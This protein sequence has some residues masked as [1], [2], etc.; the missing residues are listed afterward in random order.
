[1]STAER[2]ARE[3]EA[4]K[5]LILK[6]AK[7]LFLERGIEQTT[8][9][10]IADEIDY[11]VGT[12]YVYF[13]DKNAILHDLHSIGFQELGGYFTELFAIKDPMER[14]RKM[15]FTYL[16]F[17][18]ENSEMYDLM[19]IVKAPMEFIESTE[20]EAWTEGAD[21]FNALKKT[22]EECMNE[23]HFE[24]HSLEALSFMIWSLVHGMCCLEIRQRTKGVKFSNPDTIL[25]E[26]YNEY[27][28]IIK[29]L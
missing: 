12:V 10:N 19:F 9:R 21:T 1:M 17:A 4:L 27:L 24:G 22:V 18:M 29:K 16:K 5:M 11:S 8:I 2:K 25:S 26:G 23:G 14:L 13:K 7:K 3:K 6:G 20:K 28:K 15:G